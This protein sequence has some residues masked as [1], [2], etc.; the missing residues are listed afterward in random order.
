[1]RKHPRSW[2]CQAAGCVP[3]MRRRPSN[4]GETA[5]RATQRA[6]EQAMRKHP[7]SWLCQAAGCVP[8]GGRR[9]SD[10]GG[11]SYPINDLLAK[12]T[13]RPEQ[14]EHQRQHVGKPD[15]DTPSHKRAQVNL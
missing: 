14:Q 3:P 15:L 6:A 5:S 11:V 2:L 4:P 9:V 12:Q 1:M 8:L 7:R 13:L 10:S